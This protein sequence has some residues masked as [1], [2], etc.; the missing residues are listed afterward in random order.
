ML[1]MTL[2]MGE[3]VQVFGKTTESSSSSCYMH[4]RGK[5]KGW[6]RRLGRE[7]GIGKLLFIFFFD[8]TH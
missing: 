2:S 1:G 7:E 5:L 3:I 8:L 6:K 4:E